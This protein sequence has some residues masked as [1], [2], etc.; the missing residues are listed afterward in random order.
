MSIPAETAIE[1]ERLKAEL[2]A[3]VLDAVAADAAGNPD[4]AAALG[5]ALAERVT[6]AVKADIAAGFGAIDTKLAAL[7]AAVA[8]VQ[9]APATPIIAD[10]QAGEPSPTS[11]SP[12]SDPADNADMA[13]PV[14]EE[15]AGPAPPG[16]A[17]RFTWVVL[18]LL[19]TGV[20]LGFALGWYVGTLHGAAKPV[21]VPRI[22]PT[23]AGR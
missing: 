17:R 13:E 7:T 14:G 4:V 2:L 8:D 22:V 20:A 5:D 16:V 6:V 18:A 19:V 9:M 11:P 3:F 15:G 12:E 10:H 1:A 21:P 23:A